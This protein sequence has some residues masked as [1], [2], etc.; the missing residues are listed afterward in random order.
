MALEINLQDKLMVIL[1]S[2]LH[3]DHHG[4]KLYNRFHQSV[5]DVIIS[6]FP[7]LVSWLATSMDWDNYKDK[8]GPNSPFKLWGKWVRVY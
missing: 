7:A 8:F 4:K 1:E 3:S 5:V 2:C 6:E